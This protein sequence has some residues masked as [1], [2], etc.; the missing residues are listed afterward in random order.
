MKHPALI[1]TYQKFLS[2]PP[3]ESREIVTYVPIPQEKIA[4][5]SVWAGE[6]YLSTFHSSS[7]MLKKKSEGKGPSEKDMV[8]AKS[9]NYANCL[10]L[11]RI[12]LLPVYLLFLL[13]G[14]LGQDTK[15]LFIS[16]LLYLF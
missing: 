11:I 7:R 8:P 5:C 3:F 1:I 14:L 10:T 4:S 16:F 9:I 6:Q 2:T 13:S 15:H 12:I